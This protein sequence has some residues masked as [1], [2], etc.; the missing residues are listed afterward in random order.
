MIDWFANLAPF[1]ADPEALHR[2]DDVGP[3]LLPSAALTNARRGV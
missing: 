1:G 3:E 2:L